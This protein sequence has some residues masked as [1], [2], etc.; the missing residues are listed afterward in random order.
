ME[1]L[2]AGLETGLCDLYPLS[3]LKTVL[4]FHLYIYSFTEHMVLG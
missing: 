3:G 4:I 1:F 2:R